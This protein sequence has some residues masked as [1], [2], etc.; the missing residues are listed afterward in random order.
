MLRGHFCDARFFYA[1]DFEQMSEWM[2]AIFSLISSKAAVAST[3]A[4]GSTQD[5]N[6]RWKQEGEAVRSIDQV[7]SDE[8]EDWPE[9]NPKEEAEKRLARIRSNAHVSF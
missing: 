4:S 6:R 5:G 3:S 7:D 9:V 1:A 8:E 2:D